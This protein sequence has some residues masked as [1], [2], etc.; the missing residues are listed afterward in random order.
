MRKFKFKRMQKDLMVSTD[1]E[2]N[3]LERNILNIHKRR[4]GAYAS[5][6]ALFFSF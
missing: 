1:N 4:T 3:I 6:I 2:R 5:L